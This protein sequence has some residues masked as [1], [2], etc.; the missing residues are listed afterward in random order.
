[1]LVFQY[2]N[3]VRSSHHRLP[4]V[5]KSFKTLLYMYV[6]TI[7]RLHCSAFKWWS[8]WR[9][10]KLGGILF[11]TANARYIANLSLCSD[12]LVYIG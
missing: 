5:E 3:Q 8:R 7:H 4:P 6:W 1:M 2:H 12:K 10:L 9:R 11:S